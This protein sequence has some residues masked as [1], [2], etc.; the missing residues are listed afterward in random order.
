M[1]PCIPDEGLQTVK[2]HIWTELNYDR[3]NTPLWPRTWSESAQHVVQAARALL[4]KCDEGLSG[5]L[6]LDE[7]TPRYH[8]HNLVVMLSPAKD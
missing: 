2:R 1:L 6:L 7:L 5:Q 4:A 3:A 8:T